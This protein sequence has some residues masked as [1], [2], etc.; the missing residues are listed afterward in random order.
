MRRTKADKLELLK[1]KLGTLG[2]KLD[3]EKEHTAFLQ[4]LLRILYGRDWDKL[5]ISD[6]IQIKEKK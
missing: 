4:K 1:A 2:A 6:A 3:E 5:T